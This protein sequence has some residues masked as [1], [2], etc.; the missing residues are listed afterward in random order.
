MSSLNIVFLGTPAFSVPCLQAL[1][2]TPTIN[3]LGVLTQPDKPAGRGQKLTPPPVKVLAEQHGLKV[4]QP[5]SLRKAQEVQAWLAEVQ[6][7]FLVTIAFGQILSQAVLDIPKLGTV[8]VHASLLPQY[9]GPNPIQW[10]LLN[11]EVETGL[12]T[13]LTDIGVD[14]GAMLL[15]RSLPITSKSTT[16]SLTEALAAMAGSLL[17]ETLQT[18]AAGE[19]Q[20]TPQAHELATHAP[21]LDKQDSLLDLAQAADVL[22]R[23]VMAQNPWPGVNVH[24]AGELVKWHT[25]R[26]RQPN[27][28]LPPEAQRKHTQAGQILALVKEGLWLASAT[29]PFLLQ[30]LQPAG[31]KAM[32]AADWARNACNTLSK[33]TLYFE[34]IER[35]APAVL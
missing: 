2:N 12:T 11:G 35:Q 17:V 19:L 8:N 23:K 22:C 28:A 10:A 31:K 3:V 26:Q 15:K 34:S 13:M 27:E 21:K 20:A 4:W 6:P 24:F 16:A 5:K 18:Y 14:T 25:A 29:E 33:E 30:T 32:A 1:L 9:R 7:D